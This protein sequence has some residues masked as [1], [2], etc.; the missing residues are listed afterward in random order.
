MVSVKK[1]R[2]QH[3]LDDERLNTFPKFRNKAGTSTVATSI[4]H[5][6]GSSSQDNEK[7]REGENGNKRG[8][9]ERG[10]G[11]MRERK[12]G[13]KKEDHPDEKGR[14]KQYLFRDDV[15]I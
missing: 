8:R 4:Q 10:R 11:R 5:C 13:K 1:I 3:Q 9:E 12:G 7:E 14:S 15:V 2:R 6:T